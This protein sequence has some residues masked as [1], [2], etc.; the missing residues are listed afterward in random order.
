MKSG[1]ALY[2]LYCATTFL[3]APIVARHLHT[4]LRRRREDPERFTE[5][6]GNASAPRPAGP[7][8]WLHAASVGEVTTALTLINQLIADAPN[9]N[10]LL[11]SGTVTSAKVASQRLPAGVRHQYSP[12][13]TPQAVQ[14]FYAHWQ[15]TVGV[16]IESEIWPNLVRASRRFGVPLILANARMSERSYRAW[17]RVSPFARTILGTFTSVLAQSQADRDRLIKLGVEHATYTTSLKYAAPP[18]PA[19]ATELAQLQAALRARPRWLA[20][21]THAGEEE[22]VVAAHQRL[23]KAPNRLLTIVAP[24]HPERGAAIAELASSQRLGVSRRSCGQPISDDTDIYVADT[25]GEMGLWYRLCPLAFIG[26]SL[27]PHGGQNP[28]EAAKLECAVVTGPHTANFADIVAELKSCQALIQIDDTES[29]QEVVS[30]LLSDSAKR[31]RQV[32]SARHVADSKSDVVST[33]TKTIR[34]FLEPCPPSRI[35]DADPPVSAS[36]TQDT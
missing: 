33:I 16:L 15:P 30:E 4:R 35:T 17:Q 9:L 13:D 23:S 12:V 28:L 19:D 29:L 10:I 1:V 14:R 22:V 31:C 5:R 27:I 32:A 25:I 2:W 6:F 11:T 34:R 26:G 3:A 20:A 18:P 24:R 36:P 7:L 21:A 8:I